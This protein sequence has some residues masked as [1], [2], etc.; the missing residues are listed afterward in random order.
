MCQLLSGADPGFGKGEGLIVCSECT[1]LA[2][3]GVV[4]FPMNCNR[5]IYS[6]Q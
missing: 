3:V 1:L 5:D 4:F 6:I 2:I